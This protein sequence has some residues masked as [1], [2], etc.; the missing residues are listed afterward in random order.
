MYR[1]GPGGPE[2]PAPG[3]LRAL[4]AGGT[5]G[6]GHEARTRGSG[7]GY[8]M[9]QGSYQITVDTDQGP[10]LVPVQLDLQQA[11]KAADEK[12]KRNAG[13][14][15][16][17]RERRKEKEKQASFTISGLQAELRGVI[18]Q[19]DFYLAQRNYFCDLISRC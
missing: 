12:R 19:R 18:E 10:M 6:Y 17:F 9:G 3:A 13:A 8:Q 1:Y 15:A 11:S 16:R 4:P 7:G 5:G 2:T 14:S